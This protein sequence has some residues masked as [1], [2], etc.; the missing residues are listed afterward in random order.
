LDSRDQARRF[1][2][3][4]QATEFFENEAKVF[5]NNPRATRNMGAMMIM[6]TDHETA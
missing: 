5:G 2:A 6:E 1:P 4:G 3:A